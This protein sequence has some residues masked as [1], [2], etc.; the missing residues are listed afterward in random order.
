MIVWPKGSQDAIG[1]TG[2]FLVWATL[3]AQSGGGFHVFLP[4]LDRGIDG[5]IHRLHD[6]AYLALQVKTKSVFAHN[7]AAIAVLES[8]LYTA[9]QIVI[10]VHLD[11]DRLGDFVLVA[12]AGTF[13]K[14]AG[15]VV[16]RGRALL[17]AD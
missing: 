6:R 9:D 7:E 13:R 12:D 5:V 15:R 2:E 14:K 10:G 11:D 17:V 8:H 3:I 1:Q 16:D 4:S